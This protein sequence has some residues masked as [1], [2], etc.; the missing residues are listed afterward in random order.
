MKI[1][2]STY[3]IV[4]MHRD[5]TSDTTVEEFIMDLSE[6]LARGQPFVSIGEGAPDDDT[7]KKGDVEGRRK[8]AL[9]IKPNKA[10]IGRLIKGHVQ[11]VPEPEQAYCHG[12][13]FGDI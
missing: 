1:D 2:A 11:V 10:E 4:W 9:W 7:D 3:P 8:M 6:L 5:S 12:S 13:I